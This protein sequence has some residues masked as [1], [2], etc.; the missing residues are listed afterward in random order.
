MKVLLPWVLTFILSIVVIFSGMSCTSTST[1]PTPTTIERVF[2]SGSHSAIVFEKHADNRL[3]PKR[4]SAQFTGSIS[5]IADVP[6]GKPMYYTYVDNVY[7]IHI[8]SAKDINA[9]A[10]TG[11]SSVQ[12]G[13]IE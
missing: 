8:H 11:K 5:Y 6:I 2:C 10:T 12:M 13:V 1:P 7:E 9:G 4:L 3:V